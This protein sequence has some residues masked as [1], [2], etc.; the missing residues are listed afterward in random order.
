MCSQTEAQLGVGADDVL[1]HVL[2]VRARVADP[3]HAVDRVDR[4]Q[5]LRERRAL[6]PQVAAVGVDVLAEQRELGDAVGGEPA[7][8]L[9]ELGERAGD[10]AARASTGTMQYEQLQL[11]PTEI[12][13]QAWTSRARLGGRWPVKPSNSK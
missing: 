8:L 12:C 13:I 1:A 5:Q 10:L 2:R 7:A 9:D 11:Q 4:R 6:G 3:A